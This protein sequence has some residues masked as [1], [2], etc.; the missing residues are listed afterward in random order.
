[1]GVHVRVPASTEPA[2]ARA[3]H[4]SGTGATGNFELPEAGTGNGTQVLE[5]S[6]TLNLQPSLQ[7]LFK[8]A[9]KQ[10]KTTVSLSSGWPQA[11]CVAEGDHEFL[12]LLP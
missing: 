8:Q 2:Q 1:M 10:A 5:K 12:T 3:V 4:S 7:P 11:S 6:V 9:G